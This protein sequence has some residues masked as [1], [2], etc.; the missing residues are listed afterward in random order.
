GAAGFGF[1]DLDDKT[2]L[3]DMQG[4]YSS[5]YLRKEFDV[6]T[7]QDA[8]NLILAVAYDDG[9]VAYL[10]GVEMARANV[11]K[12]SG[13]D[14][15]V[16]F[17]R[18][19]Q[20]E[21]Q[22]FSFRN[23]RD[24]FR[25][26]APNVLAIEGHNRSLSSDDFTVDPFIAMLP[27]KQS[28]P[29]KLFPLLFEYVTGLHHEWY[30][31]GSKQDPAEQWMNEDYDV[32]KWAKGRI[33]FGF[34][35]GDDVTGLKNMENNFAR[36][37]FRT[38]F[39]IEKEDD[40]ASLGLAVRY[41]DAFIA[42]VNG[43][44]VLRVGIDFGRG[45][46]AKGIAGHEAD[47]EKY[48]FF[49]LSHARNFLS[50]DGPN[51]IAIEGHNDNLESSDFTLDPIVLLNRDQSQPMPERYTELIP[52]NAEWRY[53]AKKDGAPAEG[54]EKPEFK[55]SGWDKGESGFGYGEEAGARTELNDMKDNYRVVYMRKTFDV[56]GLKLASKA[57]LA[58]RSDDAFIAY[59]N[60]KEILRRNVETGRGEKAEK[61]TGKEKISKDFDYFP[62]GSL[63]DAFVD[64]ENVI[65]IEGHNKDV[66]SS[67]FIIDAFL[68]VKEE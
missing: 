6:K 12:G 24:S 53:I 66:T 21:Y 68:I 65:A 60:G 26:D 11:T 36:A 59:L 14:A 20:E 25:F 61:F 54:W 32:S 37:Y 62:L 28:E 67:D 64:G 16:A 2:T 13:P 45:A 55:T 39:H 15:V 49:S 7:S 51:V 22:T 5:V 57:G 27:P 35:D 10:N 18:E 4:K 50:T 40:F 47:K 42:Y 56:D 8:E 58:I 23:V 46:G 48:D 43:R 34:G 52:K 30:Y 19:A 33:G 17:S 9:F 29:E 3:S 63:H 38:E 1:G 31:Y 44:E 41:D